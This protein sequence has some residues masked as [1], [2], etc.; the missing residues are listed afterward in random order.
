MVLA[1]IA[2]GGFA[3]RL[4]GRQRCNSI[5]P[6]HISLSHLLMHHLS[7]ILPAAEWQSLKLREVPYTSVGGLGAGGN[8]RKVNYYFS[9]IAPPKKNK[10][11]PTFQLTSRKNDME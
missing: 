2:L 11:Y 10:K 3:E 8:A 4:A 1:P 5:L 9:N 6:N 7:F